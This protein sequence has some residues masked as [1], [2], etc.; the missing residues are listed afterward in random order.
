MLQGMSQA[1]DDTS[2][3]E[4][5]PLALHLSDEYFTNSTSRWGGQEQ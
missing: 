3:N 1:D 4:Y 5:V 2:Y